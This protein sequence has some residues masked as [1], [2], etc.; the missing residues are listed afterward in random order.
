MKG[1]EES[2]SIL[3]WVGKTVEWW[4]GRNIWMHHR[5]LIQR[6]TFNLDYYTTVRVPA[7]GRNS[8][9]VQN[10]QLLKYIYRSRSPTQHI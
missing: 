8:G 5:T 1:S 4:I 7:F 2:T 6:S 10:K 3:R 9:P